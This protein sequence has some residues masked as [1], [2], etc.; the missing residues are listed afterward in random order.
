MR[1]TVYTVMLS[2][3]AANL[4]SPMPDTSLISSMVLNPPLAVR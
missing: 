1:G 3:M 4:A 2:F